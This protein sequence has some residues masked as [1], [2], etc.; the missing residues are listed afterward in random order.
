MPKRKCEIGISIFPVSHYVK[1]QLG[2][3]GDIPEY[4]GEDIFEIPETEIKK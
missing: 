4:E 3:T 1:K 2:E